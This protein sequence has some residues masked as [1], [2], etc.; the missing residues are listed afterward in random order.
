[1]DITV[2]KPYGKNAKKHPKKQIEQVAA[3]I[4]EFGFNQPIVVDKENV[5]IVGHGRL[6]AAIELGMTDVPVIQVDLTTE[7]AKAYRLA[8]NK[9]NESDWDMDLVIQELKELSE[10]LLDL[11]GFERDLILEDE[12]K[13]DA[14]PEEVPAQ[15][16]YGD[17]YQLGEH[18]LLCGDATKEE[19]V[20]KLMAGEKAHMVFTDPPYNVAYEG[21]TKEKLTIENDQ[22]GKGVFADFLGKVC[23]QI[24][25]HCAGGIYICMSSSE[26]DSLKKVFETNGGHW[27][28]FI[29][30]VKNNFTFGRTDYQQMFEPILYGWPEGVVNHYFVDD[31]TKGNVWEDLQEVKT[32][33]DGEYTK[34]RF[35]GFEIKVKGKAEGSVKRKQSKSDIWRYDKP[36]KSTEH[37]TMKPVAL[38]QEAIINSSKRGEIVLDL[39]GGSGTTLIASEKT[40]RKCYMMELDPHYTDVIIKRYEDFSGNLAKKL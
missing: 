40:K 17:V 5:V 35:H 16:A 33:F 39:F 1:M 4:K 11:T 30:W 31:R 38:V 10:P 22:M 27:Q 24:N 28:N 25:K 13:D 26:M 3:S 19:D 23:E 15:A 12:A 20:E 7:Q 29:I 37:P 14:L 32:E 18:R 2:I 8:D 6:E 21:K 9:L 34:I 36:V